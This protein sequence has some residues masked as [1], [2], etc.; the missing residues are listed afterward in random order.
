M[1]I[2]TRFNVITPSKEYINQSN[3]TFSYGTDINN[4][5]EWKNSFQEMFDF[6]SKEDKEKFC[7]WVFEKEFVIEPLYTESKIILTEKDFIL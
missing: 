3:F 2:P 6:L 1:S 5:L 7:P 4:R